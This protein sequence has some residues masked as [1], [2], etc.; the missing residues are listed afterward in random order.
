MRFSFLMGSLQGVF[1]LRL[2][3]LP[4]VCFPEHL[5]PRMMPAG[6]WLARGEAGAERETSDPSLSSGRDGCKGSSPPPAPSCP[7]IPL[8]PTLACSPPAPEMDRLG[9]PLYFS[10][11]GR[12]SPPSCRWKG[13]L[14]FMERLGYPMLGRRG[15]DQEL[16]GVLFFTPLNNLGYRAQRVR[17]SGEWSTG[18]R[19]L[20]GS[21]LPAAAPA[22]WLQGLERGQPGGFP[23]VF[24]SLPTRHTLSSGLTSPLEKMPRWA[25][26]AQQFHG[27]E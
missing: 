5:C 14:Q 13:M 22:C 10:N 15:W 21:A 16:G 3:N 11:S 23:R 1:C 25:I 19:K 20:A 7:G 12:R 2:T 8:L 18:G 26:R 9:T 4:G 24:P 6:C 17:A 27:E